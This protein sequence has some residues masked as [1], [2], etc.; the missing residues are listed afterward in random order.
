MRA[1]IAPI[2]VFSTVFLSGCVPEQQPA[3]LIITGTI[4]TGN[5]SQ[6]KV[7]AVA[8]SGDRIVLAGSNREALRYKGD[9][10]RVIELNAKIMTPGFIEGHAHM[11]G[12]G[13]NEMQLDLRETESYEEMVQKVAEAIAGAESGQ[14]IVGRGWH[15]DKWNKKPE[16]MVKGFQT[17]HALS[18]VSPDNPVFLEHASG[19]LA[20]AN[21][22]AM[23]IAGLNIL[24]SENPLQPQSGEGGEVLRDSLGN[25]TGIFNENAMELIAK[26]IP[27]NDE[28]SDSTALELALKACL[29]NGITS[30]HDA[31]SPRQIIDLFYKF[32]EASKLSVRM[33]V[34][35]Q[36][37]RALLNA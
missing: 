37:D 34:M 19:H 31:G 32:K 12:I 16:V 4:Y 7:E 3:D 35:L 33:Y 13:Y 20:I 25:P 24:S 14:W 28:K 10:T 18:E 2:I 21:A 1:I 5:H 26:H 8:V 17:H 6:P 29:R 15:Q 36:Y 9:H 23:E 11:M 27:A 22:K 30:F